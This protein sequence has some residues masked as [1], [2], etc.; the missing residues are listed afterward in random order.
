[1]WWEGDGRTCAAIWGRPARKGAGSPSKTVRIVPRP[2]WTSSWPPAQRSRCSLSLCASRL[3]LRNERGS[4]FPFDLLRPERR[5]TSHDDCGAALLRLGV[6]DQREAGGSF[7]VRV[8]APSMIGLVSDAW[9]AR[10]E[11]GMVQ[12]EVERQE[13]SGVLPRRGA[14]GRCGLWAS[15]RFIDEPPPAGG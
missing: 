4:R 5:L 15:R 10:S 6:G 9:R 14:R 11:A 2:R 12:V 7:C 8:R 3:M 13:R 1:M